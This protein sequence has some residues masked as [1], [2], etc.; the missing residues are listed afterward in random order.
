MTLYLLYENAAG[1]ALFESSGLDEINTQ[2]EQVQDSI[3]DY[4]LFRK[5]CKLKVIYK[6]LFALSKIFYA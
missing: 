4:A 2:L 6:P 1:Y 3:Q 5:V